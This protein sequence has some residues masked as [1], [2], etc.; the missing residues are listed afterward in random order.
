M[1]ATRKFTLSFHSSTKKVEMVKGLIAASQGIL[2]PGAPL[3]LS[4]SGTWKVCNTADGSDAWHGLLVGRVASPATWPLTAALTANDEIYIAKID[5]A[6]IY[7]VYVEASGTDAVA[8]QTDVGDQLGLTVSATSGEVG[9]TTLDT[10]NANVVVKVVDIASNKDTTE[11]K[12]TTS[13][14]P[15]VAYVQF[16]QSII[17]SA[18]A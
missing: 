17:D 1:A 5:A 13:D 18:K 8:A 6:H 2:I 14:N 10:G 16:I 12:S 11:R 3:Y 4:Q 7:S 15:G 9:L